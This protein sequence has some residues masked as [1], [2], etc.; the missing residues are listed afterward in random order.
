MCKEKQEV[1]VMQYVWITALCIGGATLLGALLGFLLGNIPHKWKDAIIGFAAGFMLAAAVFGLVMPSME[2]V[3][4]SGIWITA[5]G[6]LVGALFLSLAGRLAPHLHHLAG[7][8]ES[9]AGHKEELDQVLLFV[10]AVAIHKLPGGL[11]SGVGFGGDVGNALEV[12]MAIAI[13]NIPEGMMV[14]SLLLL[15]GVS[16]VRTVLLAFAIGLLEVIGIFAGFFAASVSA[17]ILPF[18]LAFSGGTMLY[19]ICDDMIPETH[20]HG[21]EKMATYSI[22][23]G[24]TAM[25]IFDALH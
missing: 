23:I 5:L 14:T 19:I 6:I 24:F 1:V 21:Y 9:G 4:S 25:L 8:E 22:L 7:V 11:A 13:H 2:M 20:D 15:H 12:A 10:M 17:A 3:G 16:K 18:L